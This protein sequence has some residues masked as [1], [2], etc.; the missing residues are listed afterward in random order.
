MLPCSSAAHLYR[1]VAWIK[2]L[3]KERPNNNDRVIAVWM[4]DYAKIFQ[5]MG[6]NKTVS[7]YV[8]EKF[9][10]SFNFR[11]NIYS[12][13]VIVRYSKFG[14]FETGKFHRFNINSVW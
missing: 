3:D 12:N 9:S 11:P 4:D 14:L 5:E 2:D 8:Q 1:N 10:S 6:G 13:S 7:S